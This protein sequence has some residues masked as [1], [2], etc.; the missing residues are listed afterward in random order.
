MGL[1]ESLLKSLSEPFTQCCHDCNKYCLDNMEW[2]SQCS[3]CCHIHV[4]THAHQSDSDT[5]SE[6]AADGNAEAA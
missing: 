4:R 1:N 5:E 6:N 3:E 2:D